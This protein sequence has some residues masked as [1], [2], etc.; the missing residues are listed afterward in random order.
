MLSKK[1]KLLKAYSSLDVMLKKRYDLIPNIVEIVK[2]YKE[3]ESSTIEKVIQLRK[4]ADNCNNINDMENIA[5][6]YN[7]FISDINILSEN[8]PQLKSSD[9]FIHLQKILSEVEEE[10]SAARRTYNAHVEKYNT[11]ISYVPINIFAKI[12]NFEKYDFFEASK[13][14]RNFN[15]INK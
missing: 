13:E 3:Y 15:Y 7:S 1:N 8:Y 11:Y 2:E 12:F 4:N 5:Q 14:E 6:K 9:N 10:I